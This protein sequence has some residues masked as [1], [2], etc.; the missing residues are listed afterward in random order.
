MRAAEAYWSGR[1]ETFSTEIDKL[2]PPCLSVIPFLQSAV[3]VNGIE[4]DGG[5]VYRTEVLEQF[6]KTIGPQSRA[7]KVSMEANIVAAEAAERAATAIAKLDDTAK[8]FREAVKNDLS[9]MK[10]SSDRVQNEV[11]QMED[12]YRFAAAMLTSPDFTR[13][14]ENAE[15][16]ATALKA[17][18]ELSETKLSVA[19]FGGGKNV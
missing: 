4:R 16:M 6:E 15:R 18:S 17:I 5:V 13:A 11:R 7:W 19:V 12:R 9:S 2:Y 3:L 14:L 10:A 1:N 8:R